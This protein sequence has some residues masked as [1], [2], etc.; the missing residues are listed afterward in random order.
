MRSVQWSFDK[1]LSK[2]VVTLLA[3]MLVC[4]PVV[5][6][7]QESGDSEPDAPQPQTKLTQVPEGQGD[8]ESEVP[9]SESVLEDREGQGDGDA[10]GASGPEDDVVMGGSAS[11]EETAPSPAQK[12]SVSKHDGSLVYNYAIEVPEGRN[13]L[14][15]NHSLVYRSTN[16]K[17]DNIFGF[18][19]EVDIPYIERSKK[20]GSNNIYTN[21]E[22]I[23]SL[24]EE[25]SVQTGGVYKPRVEKGDFRKYEKIERQSCNN[26]LFEKDK[27]THFTRY[28]GYG[29]SGAI[30]SAIAFSGEN[31]LVLGESSAGSSN[32]GALYTLTKNN[33]QWSLVNTI[34]GASQERL[35]FPLSIS[36]NTLVT[37]KQIR[38]GNRYKPYLQ[39][40][41]R[42]GNGWRA[43][44]ERIP[45][46]SPPPSVPESISLS[47]NV[48]AVSSGYGNGSVSIYEKSGNSWTKSQKLSGTVSDG[49]FGRRVSLSGGV[50]VVGAWGGANYRRVGNHKGTVYLFE[51][52][53]NTW[54][55]TLKIFDRGTAA[56]VS[57]E[58]HID[59]PDRHYFGR[60]V[61]ISGNTLVIGAADTMYIFKKI[62]NIWSLDKKISNGDRNDSSLNEIRVP[63]DWGDSFGS[64]GLASSGNVL[65]VGARGDDDAGENK[66]AVYI[67]EEE[68]V[69]TD[70]SYWRMT[71]KDGTQYYFGQS[72]EARQD[73]TTNDRK[74]IFKWMLEKVEDTNGNTIKYTYHKHKG[75]IYPERI[76]YVNTSGTAYEYSVRFNRV[77]RTDKTKMY[78]KAF[79]VTT[80]HILDDIDVYKGT[81]KILVY[82]IGLEEITDPKI[83][84]LIKS[85][86]KEGKK[87]DGTWTIG[88][89]TEFTYDTDVSYTADDSLKYY[90]SKVDF[91]G[92]SHRDSYSTTSYRR[93]NYY[94]DGRS[95]VEKKIVSRVKDSGSTDY[96]PVNRYFGV[97]GFADVNGDY[98]V[99]V[100]TKHPRGSTIDSFRKAP[101]KTYLST[102]VNGDY[103]E[104]DS[105]VVVPGSRYLSYSSNTFEP[106]HTLIDLNNDK[107][108][109]YI[110]NSR[111]YGSRTRPYIKINTGT[112][113]LTLGATTQPFYIP[114]Q[115]I[116]SSRYRYRYVN[117]QFIDINGDNLPDIVY[118]D[119]DRRQSYYR[120]SYSYYYSALINTGTRWVSDSDILNQMVN[121]TS[122]ALISFSSGLGS[123][124]WN[125]ESSNH[126]Y[127]GDIND[128]GLVD[129]ITSVGRSPYVKN[130]YLNNGMAKFLHSQK[131]SEVL[132]ATGGTRSLD[133]NADGIPD[134]SYRVIGQHKLELK[135]IT[136]EYGGKY[137]FTYDGAKPHHN[138][139]LIPFPLRIV[140]EIAY[141]DAY[142][143]NWEE[144]MKYK[145]GDFYYGGPYDRKFS[146][147]E[148]IETVIGDKVEKTYYHQHNGSNASNNEPADSY[149]KM[150]LPYKTE[151]YEK[152]EDGDDVKYK[153]VEYSY[154]E[155]NDGT[156]STFVYLT[157]EKQTLY[158][159]GTADFGQETSNTTS[160]TYDTYGNILSETKKTGSNI[161]RKTKYTYKTPDSANYIVALP[162]TQVIQDASTA[163]KAKTTYTYN[164]KGNLLTESRKINT[165]NNQTVTNTYNAKGQILT[166]KDSL[167]N[168]TTYAYDPQSLRLISRTNPKGHI[169]QYV[170]NNLGNVTKETDPNGFEVKY[171]YDGIGRTTAVQKKQNTSLETAVEYAYNFSDR[172][173]SIK[174]TRKYPND[175][176]IIH[177]YFDGFGRDIQTR[178]TN[179]TKYNTTDKSYNDWGLVKDVFTPYQTLTAAYTP[180]PSSTPKTTTTYDVLG[181]VLSVITPIGTTTSVYRGNVVEITSPENRVK[182][183]EYDA[184][185]RLK[186]IHEKESAQFKTTTYTYD[187]L[188]RLIQINDADDNVRTLTYDM[189]GNNLSISDLHDKDDTTYKTKTYTYNQEYRTAETK[190]DG[191]VIT[192]T[193]D[194][195]GRVLTEDR[196]T[197]AGT[198]YTFVYDTC[199]NGKGRL[200]SVI[201]LD[202]VTVAYKYDKEGNRKEEAKTIAG[203]IYTTTYEY[204]LHNQLKKVTTPDGKVITYTYGNN[205]KTILIKVNGSVFQV[206]TYNAFNKIGTQSVL[207][208]SRESNVYDAVGR[209][210]QRKITS[211]AMNVAR[212]L[213]YTYD[214]DSNVT[215]VL[216]TNQAGQVLTKAYVYDALNRLTQ[217]SATGITGK[218]Y[219]RNYTYD[220]IGNIKTKTGVGTYTYISDGDTT[221]ITPHQIQSIDTA[222]YTYDLNGN[223]TSNGTHTITWDYKDRASAVTKSADTYTYLYDY[224]GNRV[225]EVQGGD[226]VVYVNPYYTIDNGTRETHI[227]LDGMVIGS[228]TTDPGINSQC[229]LSGDNALVNFSLGSGWNKRTNT[230]DG[231]EVYSGNDVAAT[232]TVNDTHKFC[233]TYKN[234]HLY[235]D[236]LGSIIVAVDDTDHTIEQ[237][238][239]YYPYGEKSINEQG[240]K[241]FNTDYTHTGNITDDTGLIYRNARYYDPNTG[242]FI[243][244]DPVA[245]YLG[246]PAQFKAMTSMPFINYLTEPQAHNTYS[247]ALNNPMRY[248]DRNGELPHLVVTTLVGA[249]AGLAFQGAVDLITGD[250]SG[251]HAY[252]G[253]LAGGATGGF[254][255]G[256]GVGASVGFSVLFGGVSGL[257]GGVTEETVEMW[258]GEDEEDKKFNVSSVA[259]DIG[260][261]ALGGFFSGTLKVPGVNKGKGSHLAVRNSVYTG[262]QRNTIQTF[263]PRTSWKMFSS[264]FV[265]ELP[266]QAIQHF[267]SGVTREQTTH[268]RQVRIGQLRRKIQELQ[269]KLS[270]LKRRP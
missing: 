50:L 71:D 264:T 116:T 177:T 224:E 145:G 215:Q 265:E 129:V 115:A 183:L 165:G 222:T 235:T 38:V 241:N 209:L 189:A 80:E 121:K 142:A 73:G 236:H 110:V 211:S 54:S 113:A 263:S 42:S 214:K 125:N 187:T 90:S 155:T 206:F 151:I 4:N 168:T 268:S 133:I 181:R 103:E 234:T 249:A 120:G 104:T 11:T 227:L 49:Y 98:I 20:K 77:T 149:A 262:L 218:T 18:G 242:R 88:P 58:M 231:V 230:D 269:S 81:E 207:N 188:D 53:N 69:C 251:W 243:S 75:Q 26:V 213:D 91:N 82:N 232:V 260:L 56:A 72:L 60:S 225:Q 144:E 79:P 152:N 210:T 37:G 176:E 267:G 33:G 124:S 51:K 27:I 259:I 78:D 171:T 45:S 118:E 130:V 17:P 31:T 19:W 157:D 182:R 250:F 74:K 174:E 154:G 141:E 196:T 147:F 167:N 136:T 186:K 228:S 28:G 261:G 36:G 22:Y 246:N 34:T 6:Y 111:R 132:S 217:V 221:F 105:L 87:N 137:T 172:P 170:Y 25:L 14:T 3:V 46:P 258:T 127:F 119:R 114:D 59:L 248:E 270:K 150:N 108:P 112:S 52:V 55:Q 220:S 229:T 219:T 1:L 138:S 184:Y 191:T 106:F 257:V 140:T 194:S 126:T 102:S 193:Y 128:D 95:G 256:T 179:G 64:G 239:D 240:T 134:F 122:G 192:Y 23:S 156:N 178:Q 89:K 2:G 159:N 237:F 7:A 195:L 223:L 208:G 76:D 244:K 202:G 204:N 35:G 143:E 86:H 43:L 15:P 135:E 212:K 40:Y 253:A 216:D 139:N 24:D 44:S 70:K 57:G 47:G 97:M 94:T 107:L 160:Y 100:I 67:F 68:E 173:Y 198:D 16:R 185:G 190:R 148:T 203:T 65:A 266:S 66:G 109:D 61:N 146:G 197:V 93:A 5:G 233:K 161:L 13:G 30:G 84:H 21:E 164:S 83:G 226:T 166:T 117:A 9:D 205:G 199:E 252:A 163:E 131:Y 29:N 180:V 92:D 32:N 99:D 48:L 63:L 245:E 200:C 162:A 39:F 41:S 85:I 175:N 8:S 12:P 238:I 153:T 169:T 255:I 158:K 254:L 123:R 247:Y 62:N 101:L 96:V 10:A 201:G